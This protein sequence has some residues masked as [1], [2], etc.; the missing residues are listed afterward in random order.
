MNDISVNAE[1][2]SY[3]ISIIDIFHGFHCVD[4]SK[5]LDQ[6]QE[7]NERGETQTDTQSKL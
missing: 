2:T 4:R 5:R 3:Y 6:P 7:N 1:I